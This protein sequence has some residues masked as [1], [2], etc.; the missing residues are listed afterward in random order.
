[1]RFLVALLITVMAH[2]AVVTSL[3]VAREETCTSRY[4]VS[5]AMEDVIDMPD[6]IGSSAG[7]PKWRGPMIANRSRGGLVLAARTAPHL[8]SD[9]PALAHLF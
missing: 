3:P 7:G 8:H 6:V 5:I 1:M 4:R 2:R 9:G